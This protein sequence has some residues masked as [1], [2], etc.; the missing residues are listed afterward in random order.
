MMILNI[1][2]NKSVWRLLALVSYS[3]GA[4]YTR[5]E[6]MRLLDWN[7]ISLDRA[8]RK[9]E[10][11]K[12][13]I[14]EKRLIRLDFS[15]KIT[16]QLLDIVEQDKKMLNYPV[17]NLF[18]VLIELAG[19]L[20]SY[21]IEA[22]L[23]GSHAKKTARVD[24]DIDIAIISDKPPDLTHLKESVSSKLQ[25]HYFKPKDRARLMQEVRK[26]GVRII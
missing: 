7:N 8:L 12:V 24:S 15:Q 5:T 22:C 23:F 21:D 17:F 20:E 16:G 2:N 14:R 26:H 6:L 1:L 25:F 10:A 13:L 11:N 4:S 19:R 3:P 18:L 9:L